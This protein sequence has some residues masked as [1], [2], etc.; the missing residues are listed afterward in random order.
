[1]NELASN[2][3]VDCDVYKYKVKT[4]AGKQ[5]VSYIA[6]DTWKDLPSSLKDLSVFVFPKYIKR[7]LLSEQKLNQFST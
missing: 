2:A 1:M 3:D 6:V 5:S 7:Y 4:N